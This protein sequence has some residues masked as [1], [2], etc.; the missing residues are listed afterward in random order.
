MGSSESRVSS[1]PAQELGT[2]IQKQLRPYESCEKQIQE[3]VGV[4]CSILLGGGIPLVQGVAVGGC[5][6]RKT[7]LRGDSHGTLVLFLSCLEHFQDQTKPQDEILKSVMSQ[8]EDSRSRQRLKHQWETLR[9]PGGISIR[10]S[11]PWQKVT[12]E[13]L[14]AF[15]ALSLSA[16]PTPWLYRELIRSMD[17]TKAA[18]GKF[19]VCF[20]QLQEKFFKKYPPKVKDLIL[21]MKR[22]Y[23]QCPKEG[24]S[25]EPLSTYALELLAVYAWEQGCRAED[26]NIAEGV[27]AILG[28]I[29]RPEQL[30]VYWTVNYNLEDATVRNRLLRQLGSKRPV[31]L[32][33]VDLTHNVGGYVPWQDLQAEA[34]AWLA[35]L[36]STP[37][38]SV[39]PAPLFM[40]PGHQLDKFIKDFL[41]P[42]EDFLCQIRKAVDIICSFLRETC[43]KSSPTKVQRIIKG[44][45]TAKGT[46]L[47]TGSDADIVVFL[48]SLKSFPSQKT[49][50]SEIVQEIRTQL[51]ACRQQH[52]FEVKFEISKWTAPRVLS[53][54]LKSQHLNESVDFDVLPAYD[55]LGPGKSTLWA[56]EELINVYRSS[57]IIGGEFST[58]FTELQRD[59]ILS[60]PTKLKSCIRL[61]KYWYKQCEKKMKPKGS[62]PPK[63]ALELLTIYAWQQGNGM[64]DFSTAEGF[65]T[66]LELV[67]KYQQLSIYWTDNYNFQDE[68]TRQ[69]LLAQL[70]RTRPIILDP[71]EPTGDV[72]GGDR[73]CWHLLAK[74]AKEWFSS[75][76]FRDGMGNSVQPWKVPTMQGPRSSGARIDPVAIQIPSDRSHFLG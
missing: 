47:K 2:F 58:C 6:G 21:L 33:P 26:F 37:A 28:L 62:L 74:E 27:R 22:W 19:S 69:F 49:Y 44:G 68:T 31:I 24:P 35:S 15:N 20:A 12:F 8:L 59:F 13:V 61:V 39:L 14:A 71:A 3:T 32:D 36:S 41:E 7:V 57:D 43:F 60:Q 72:G 52:Q 9:T 76:C 63:Y 65:R 50:R 54:S 66:V 45:S 25:H 4:I 48:S 70:Q 29:R 56:Y 5:Y 53:F 67:T 73:W 11:T 18:P 1:V 75:L 46:A 17:E 34:Q 55:A 51:E 64:E 42:N 38:W 16:N 40:T 23:R 10:V 30:C